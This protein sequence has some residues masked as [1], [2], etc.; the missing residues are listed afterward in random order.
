ME[1]TEVKTEVVELQSIANRILELTQELEKSNVGVADIG[2]VESALNHLT[3]A[4]DEL[5]K[6]KET[7]EEEDEGL[8]FL[9]TD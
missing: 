4:R 2:R 1:E 5:L 7:Y 8:G 6:L 3:D 9:P